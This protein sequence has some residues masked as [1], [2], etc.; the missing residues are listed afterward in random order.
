MITTNTIAQKMNIS[1]RM[2]PHQNTH[3]RMFQN[4]KQK[5]KKKKE[6]KEN[7]KKIGLKHKKC[8]TSF[9]IF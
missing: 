4:K 8:S 2:L 1:N 9:E 5:K 7:P 6:P 3:I